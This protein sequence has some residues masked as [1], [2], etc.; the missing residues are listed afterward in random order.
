MNGKDARVSISVR[1]WPAWLVTCASLALV[2]AVCVAFRSTGTPNAQAQAPAR[3]SARPGTTTARPAGPQNAGQVA[4][5]AAGNAAPNNTTAK[6]LGT[7]SATKAAAPASQVSAVVNG[8]QI[9]RTELGRECI[10]R[11][12]KEVLESLISKQLIADACARQ[13]IVITEADVTAEIDRIAAKFGLSRDRWEQLLQEERGFTDEQYRREVVWPMMALRQLAASETEV[14]PEEIKKAF[15]SEFG[16]KVRARL[17]AVEK[18]EIADQLLAE[19]Q[20]NPAQFGELSKKHSKDPGVAAA[21]G[22]IPPIRRHLGDP[23]LEQIAF[24]LKPGQISPVINVANMYYIIKCEEQIPQQYIASQHLAEQQRR[25]ADRIKESKLRAAA[26]QFFEKMEKEAQIVNVL[27]EPKKQQELPG[28]AATVNGKPIPLALLAE[29]CITRHGMEVLDGEINRKLLQQELDRKKVVVEGNDIDAEVARA[30]VTYGFTK[31]DKTP[32]IENWLKKIESEDGATVDLYV[33]DAVWPS[34]A[35]KKLVGDRVEVTQEDLQKGYEA[36]YGERV[37]VLAIVVGDH[38]QAQKVWDLARNNPTDAFF[39]ELAQQYS[40]EPASRS[41][42]G[43]V[44]PIPRHGGSPAVEEEAFKLKRG[45]LSGIVAVENQ[46]IIMKCLGRTRPVQTD[47][48][49][50]KVELAKDIQ[51]KKLRVMMTKEFDRIRESAQI[52]NFL[53]GLTQ[54]P[55]KGGAGPIAPIGS[56]PRAGSPLGAAPARQAPPR[57]G[58]V[59]PASATLPQAATPKTR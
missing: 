36:N 32:D 49:S 1:R 24:S 50:I 57:A 43:K 42:G 6:P 28:V 44:P 54:S 3:I 10:R 11:Y 25:L 59:A 29:E 30:A 33:R 34:V 14:T 38:R 52:D 41:N 8:Q 58:S 26:G 13:S 31:P 17:I 2:G 7:A 4:R 12:G 15:E 16:A 56:S 39:G 53:A 23:N 18:Q 19:A 40:V 37:E 9:T 55:R 20:A 47:F 27:K 5:P 46:F 21:Y 22:V 48:E 45:E 51:E 35:L